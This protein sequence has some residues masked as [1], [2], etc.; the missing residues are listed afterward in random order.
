YETA[1]SNIDKALGLW[2]D[3]STF[4]KEKARVLAASK[5]PSAIGPG[6]TIIDTP[7]PPSKSPC[8]N[9]LAGHGKRKKG[10][11]FDMVSRSA[12]G[13]LMVVVPNGE[14][15]SRPFAIGK[16][17]VT[18]ADFNK[19]CQLSTACSVVTDR[20]KRLPISGISLEQATAYA[21]WLSDRTGNTYRLP[22]INEWIYAAD[23]AGQQPRKD[24]NCRVEQSGQ[25]LKGQ[26]TIG[27]NTGKANGWGLYNYVGNVQEWAQSSD[28]V[29][30]RGGAYEDTF[31]KCAI[32]LEKPHGGTPDKSTGFRL[33]Q[34]LG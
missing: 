21:K 24:Y 25:I 19:Y 27:V 1:N 16:Y 18:V 13:P 5:Q 22:T 4:R 31:S 23:A 15:F 10:T 17:E 8:T 12:R 30:V 14:Q 26:S 32:S 11:C 20:D 34:E 28:G 33:L 7:P 3:S 9:K 6:G 29:V 2:S